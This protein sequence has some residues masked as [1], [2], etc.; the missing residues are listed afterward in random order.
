M[1]CKTCKDLLW[2]YCDGDLDSNLIRQVDEHTA[3]CPACRHELAANTATIRFLH[4][5]MP[6]L[7]P[8]NAF[9]QATLDK[10]ALTEPGAFLKPMIGISLALAALLL[11]GLVLISPFFISLLWLTGNIIVTLLQQGAL[12]IKTAPLLQITSGT[13]L[14]ALL[15]IVLASMRRLAVRRIA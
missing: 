9:V 4:A 3:T 12:V 2:E 15:F 7:M 11:T 5:H 6:V 14:T 8:D 1:D 10:I 13:V